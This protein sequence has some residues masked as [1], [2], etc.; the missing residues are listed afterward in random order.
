M[1]GSS[2][3]TKTIE[4][5]DYQWQN[6]SEGPYLLSDEKWR[7]QVSHNILDEL[8]IN[9]EEI[10]GMRVLDAGCGQGRWAHG[11]VKLNCETHGFD[12]SRHGIEYAK[13]HV[14]HAFFNVANVLDYESLQ[15]LYEEDSFDIVWC[16]GVLHHTGDPELG[17]RNLTKFVKPGGLIHLYIYGKKPRRT[18]VIRRIFGFFPFSIRRIL[19]IFL[20]I[21]L[22]SSSHSNFDM[23]SPPIASNHTESEVKKW[24]I[25]EGLSFKRIHPEWVSGSN[26]IFTSGFKPKEAGK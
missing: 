24:Y 10:S 2:I 18:Q 17:F 7:K 25:D 19:A 23:F 8:N 15:K 12:P 20:S 21:F 4:S 26:D 13:K 3:E 9:E 22:S 16:W 5:F 6:L 1:E 11:F 14:P